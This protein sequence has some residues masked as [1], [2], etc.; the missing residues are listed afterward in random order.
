MKK[1]TL[2]VILFSTFSGFSQAITITQANTGSNTVQHIVQDILINSPCAQV[3]N[4][5]TQGLCG[6]GN[7]NYTGT[8]FDFSGGMILRCGQV[9]NSAGQYTNA[10][11]NPNECSNTGDAELLAISQANGN[12]G[13]TNDVTF[14]KFDFTPL[15][16]NFSFNFIF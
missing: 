12:P 7:F 10:P 2:L 15:T 14:V 13:S 11:N 8:G 9:T 6:V 16:D 3:S 5:Q 1:I 4:F